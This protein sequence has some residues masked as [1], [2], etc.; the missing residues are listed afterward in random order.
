VAKDQ[1][2]FWEEKKPWSRVKDDLLGHYLRAYFQKILTTRRPTLYVDGFAGRGE[3]EDGEP[4]SPL[5]ALAAAHSSIRCTKIQK[6]RGIEMAFVEAAFGDDLASVLEARE[7]AWAPGVSFRVIEGRFEREVSALAARA[8]GGNLFVYIDPFGIKNLEHGLITRLRNTGTG[9]RGVELLIN[10]NSFGF[11]RAACRAMKVKYEHDGA[12]VEAD[13]E[14]I[15]PMESNA[16]GP[17]VGLLNEV[18]GGDYWQTI[19]DA[20]RSGEIDGNGAERRF[21]EAYRL[22]LS[23][24]YRYVL[25]MPIRLG[26][27][28]P[29]KYRMVHATNHPDGCV[30]M[31]ENM[32]KRTD[33]LYIYLPGHAQ[34]SLFDQDVE[35]AI[36]NPAEVQKRIRHAT[37]ELR[38]FT[39]ANE[40]M[41]TFYAS[42]G[43][44]CKPDVVREEWREMERSGRIEVRRDPSATETGK[45]SS[46]LTPAKGKTVSI[47]AK[48]P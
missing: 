7:R 23:E 42:N 35:G 2:G 5:I 10:L 47:R 30:L 44:I 15:D 28:Q 26:R 18:A 24:A 41:A 22:K 9:P 37:A 39:G 34:A 14:L 48:Q 33:D 43:V 11:I 40:A 6:H 32:M 16:G 27:R 45:P 25:S 20:Y 12:L 4:G 38:E 21:A 36:A 46:F 19:I 31:A 13:D 3:F 17:A 1:A 8:R 29:P